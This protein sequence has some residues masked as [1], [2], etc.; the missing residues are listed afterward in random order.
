MSGTV[1]KMLSEIYTQRARNNEAIV[2]ALNV[3]LILKG[4]FPDTYTEETP[5]DEETIKKV[6]LI[7]EEMGV[8]V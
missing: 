7:A 2:K 8:K 1:K 6:Q 3:K 5:D 4:V